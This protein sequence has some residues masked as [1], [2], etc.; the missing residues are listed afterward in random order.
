M[1]RDSSNPTRPPSLDHSSPKKRAK[2]KEE[3]PEIRKEGKGHGPPIVAPPSAPASEGAAL[4]P[5]KTLLFLGCSLILFLI[6]HVTADKLGGFSEMAAHLAPAFGFPV[7]TNELILAYVAS[8]KGILFLCAVAVLFFPIFKD[9]RRILDDLEVRDVFRPLAAALLAFILLHCLVFHFGNAYMGDIY[10]NRS[11]NPFAQNTDWYNKRLLM[12][13]LAH[14]LFFR[15]YWLYY[16]FFNLIFLLFLGLL[17][18]WVKEKALLS[19]WQFLSLA[20]CS[21]A[22]YQ[23]QSPGYPDVLVFVFFML[24]MHQ[25]FSQDAKLSLLLLALVTH[26]TSLFVGVVLAWRYLERDHRI[27]YLIGL[28]IYGVAWAAAYGF[29]MPALLTSHN[30]R[31]RSGLQWVALHPDAELL[32]IFMAFKAVWLLPI[33]AALLAACRRWYAEVW[34][35]LACVA[36]GLFMTLLGLDTSR[37]VGFGFPGVLVAICVIRQGLSEKVCNRFLSIVLLANLLIPSWCVGLNAWIV[38]HPGL[39]NAWWLWLR[40]LST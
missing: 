10:A 4:S 7:A 15:D 20:T 9:T 11:L 5:S 37:L 39:Y 36:A 33:G 23:C 17:Y 18:S 13:A 1:T 2:G 24:V 35:I 26:E 3:K 31:G 29:V 34:F 25:G 16:V 27:A 19:F 21:F 30:Y 8:F 40:A 6:V 22:I 38:V 32:G 28:G 14:I 12:P